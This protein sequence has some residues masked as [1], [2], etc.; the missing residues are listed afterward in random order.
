MNQIKGAICFALV[1]IALAAA[2]RL[3]LIADKDAGVMFAI[4]PAVWIATTRRGQSCR[5]P[6][7]S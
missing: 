5:G 3:G 6:L 4:V 7:R 2:S 1:L